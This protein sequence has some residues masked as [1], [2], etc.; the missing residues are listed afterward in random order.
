[1]QHKDVYSNTWQ[2]KEL[3]NTIQEIVSEEI[4][5]AFDLQLKPINESL[6]LLV[7]KKMD[8]YS[9]EVESLETVA[10]V[11]EERHYDLD[12][13]R[14]MAGFHC[15]TC[16]FVSHLWPINTKD[17]NYI[18]NNTLFSLKQWQC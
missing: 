15:G 14:P 5:S 18:I 8:T 17:N 11:T 16:L 7:S 13:E 4:T 1:M 10:N 6:A 9:T 12:G 2:Q 3:A